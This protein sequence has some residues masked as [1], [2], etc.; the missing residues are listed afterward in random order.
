MPVFKI[1]SNIFFIFIGLVAIILVVSI[2][3]VTGNYKVLIVQSG[4]MQ[5]TIKTGSLIISKPES[6]YEVG[7]I[8]TFRYGKTTIT[9]R[10]YEKKEIDNQTSYVTKGDA[11]NASDKNEISSSDIVGKVFFHMPY[12][13]YAVDTAKKPLGFMLVVVLPALIIIFDEAKN[14]FQEI[15]KIRAKKKQ[16]KLS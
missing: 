6:M 5:P 10:V 2:F 8:I 14:I 13:G 12:L 15:K 7:D 16:T 11:N 1:I 4:S 9:H 3:P